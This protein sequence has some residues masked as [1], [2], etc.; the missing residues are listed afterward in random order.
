MCAITAYDTS[1]TTATSSE[2]SPTTATSETSP[3]TATPETSPTTTTSETP[4]TTAAASGAVAGIVVAAGSGERLGVGRPKAM[5]ELAGRPMFQWAAAT[6]RDAGCDRLVIV[7]PPGGKWRQFVSE[8]EPAALVVMGGVTRQ[9]SVLSALIELANTPPAVV[10]VHDAARALTPPDVAARVL[11]AVRA[12]HRCVT[13]V[14]PMS[15][16]VR[17]VGVDGASAIMDRD[18]LRAVQTP[19]GFDFATL[20]DAHAQAAAGGVEATD[21]VALCE[22]RG[23]RVWLTDGD[24]RAFKITTALDLDLARSLSRSGVS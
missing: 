10:L 11:A 20:L 15:D 4:P 7:I 18:Q 1:P 16:T 8:A 5:I 17:V 21:D 9:Q 6:L 23:E 3:T 12:G 22:L 2:T 14:V 13:P 19:Q 24:P